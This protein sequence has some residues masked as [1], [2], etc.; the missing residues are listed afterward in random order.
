MIVEED[1]CT[2]QRPLSRDYCVSKRACKKRKSDQEFP[3]HMMKEL[4]Y[5]TI[6]DMLDLDPEVRCSADLNILSNLLLLF[7]VKI[8]FCCSSKNHP[9]T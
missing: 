5:Q 6:V 1:K 7:L 8:L 3:E 4:F 2:G 9:S